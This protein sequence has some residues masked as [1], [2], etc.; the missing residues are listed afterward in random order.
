MNRRTGATCTDDEI[1][2]REQW[3]LK[4]DNEGVV[5]R[6]NSA[7]EGWS[8]TKWLHAQD[9]DVWESIANERE[10]WMAQGWVIKVRWEPSRAGYGGRQSHG[11]RSHTSHTES[12]AA[13]H[14]RDGLINGPDR[15][16]A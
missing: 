8:T 10:R 2:V 11:H 13:A 4:L 15:Q 5:K 14:S 12:H 1:T 16:H 6:F 3:V 9:R 7:P